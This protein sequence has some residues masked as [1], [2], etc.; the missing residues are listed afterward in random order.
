MLNTDAHSVKV[1]KKSKMTKE[2]FIK[3][4][5]TNCRNEMTAEDLSGIYQRIVEN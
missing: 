4:V 5:A 3:N 1:D 2:Q